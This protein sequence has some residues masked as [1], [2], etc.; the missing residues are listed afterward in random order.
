MRTYDDGREYKELSARF[1]SSIIC[2]I[3]PESGAVWQD[4]SRAGVRKS[5]GNVKLE[6]PE[7]KT[8]RPSVKFPCAAEFREVGGP[9][10]WYR[11]QR[12]HLLLSALRLLRRYA[13]RNDIL[14]VV[15]GHPQQTWPQ[16][17]SDFTLQTLLLGAT[18]YGVT[19]NGG[20]NALKY[21]GR[22]SSL[23]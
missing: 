21:S 15:G 17:V 9:I 5:E 1:R 12:S 20:Q 11:A 2:L 3:L 18:P 10:L 23:S 13:P 8:E 7:V 19:A 22:P 6:V 4:F 16:G 14:G